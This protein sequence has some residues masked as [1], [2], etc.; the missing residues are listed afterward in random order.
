MEERRGLLVDISFN[1][2]CV[3]FTSWSAVTVSLKDWCADGDC[4]LKFFL[5][6][7]SHGTSP[8]E[9][10]IYCKHDNPNSKQSCAWEVNPMKTKALKDG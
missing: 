1:P 8:E 7:V 4:Y 3:S 9:H 6:K 10:A 2:V 5:Y